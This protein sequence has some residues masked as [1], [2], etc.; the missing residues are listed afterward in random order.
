MYRC[1]Y[2][3]PCTQQA[4]GSK[5]YITRANTGH[6]HDWDNQAGIE[7]SKRLCWQCKVSYQNYLS[8]WWKPPWVQLVVFAVLWMIQHKGNSTS[9]YQLVVHSFSRVCDFYKQWSHQGLPS[10]R[11]V[12]NRVEHWCSPWLDH[13]RSIG[14]NKR[15]TNHGWPKMHWI[16]CDPMLE[17]LVHSSPIH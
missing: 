16:E 7:R 14:S 4:K 3:T 9:Y 5:W 10:Q 6:V 12:H 15:C 1:P 11:Y 17:R 8:E 2:S 13:S